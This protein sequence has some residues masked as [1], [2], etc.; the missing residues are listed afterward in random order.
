MKINFLIDTNIIIH[1]GL[2]EFISQKENCGIIISDMTIKELDRQ[3]YLDG[4]LGYK[5]RKA[6]REL[7]KIDRYGNLLDWIKLDNNVSVK[8]EKDFDRNNLNIEYSCNDD[9]IMG[10]LCYCNKIYGKTILATNDLSFSLKA[11]SLGF[12]T[13]KSETNNDLYKDLF[14]GKTEIKVNDDLIDKFYAG[15]KIAPMDIKIIPS[16]NQFV[17]MESLSNPKKKAITIYK[18]GKL[19]KLR[20][21]KINPAGLEPRNLEQKLAIELLMDDSIPMVTLTGSAGSAKTILELACALEKIEDGSSPYKKIVIA[22]PPIALDKNL[23]VGYKKGSM[24]D[25]YIHTL[26][27]ITSNLEVLKKDRGNSFMNGVKL[28]EGWID[29]GKIE[30]CSLEDILGSSYNNSIILA[31]E[32]QL[33]TKPNMFGL[34]SRLGNSRLFITGDINQSSRMI[35]IDSREM[36]LYHT[37]NA[38]KDSNLSGHLKLETIQRSKFVEELYKLW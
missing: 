29:V 19:E 16:E 38:F 22:K 21:D 2:K 34:L 36:G 32:L 35:N 7:D 37:V 9:V 3:K 23:H 1:V 13:E 15:K 30:I 33:L 20:Y 28:L 27:S 8:V 6:I 17:I 11:K 12:T 10:C 31:D 26:G 24:V 5:A 14:T 4:E 18:D 25:K